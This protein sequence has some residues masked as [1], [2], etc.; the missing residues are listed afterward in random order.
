MA[1]GPSSTERVEQ[2]PGAPADRGFRGARVSR[3]AL[4]SFLTQMTTSALAGAL[5][6]FLSRALGSSGYGAFAFAIGVMSILL[7]FGDFGISPST[8]RF[9]AEHR[10]SIRDVRAIFALALRLKFAFAAVV[11][12][13]MFALAGPIS[14][15]FGHAA[16]PWTLRAAAIALFGQSVLQ[17]PLGSFEAL[18]RISVSWRIATTESVIEVAATVALVLGSA[19]ATSAMFGRAIG[20]TAGTALALVFV[21]RALGGLRVPAGAISPV[22]RRR[23]LG[24]AVPLLL[25]D[26]LFRLF[27]SIDVLLIAAI[28]GGGTNVAIYA[29]PMRL[30]WFLHYPVGSVASAVVPRLARGPDGER[31]VES[32]AVTLRYVVVLQMALVPPILVWAGPIIT[33]VSGPHYAAAIPVLRALA[34]FVFLSGL[35]MLLSLAVNY[36]GEARRRVP[37][38]AAALALNTVIDVLLLR[39]IG[40]IAGAYG[41]TAAYVVWTLAHLRILRRA[42]ALPLGPLLR[43][44]GRS[45][46]AAAAMSGVLLAFGTEHLSA[47]DW[48]AGSIAGAAVYGAVLVATR[49]LHRGDLAVARRILRRQPVSA[50]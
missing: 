44:F 21:A 47:F 6:V 18:R 23:L 30:A 19:T 7:L 25:V 50:A 1:R 46:L 41:S 45:L 49:E 3:N 31:D 8:N 16:S 40:P 5:T 43:S 42:L 11:S 24:Y 35:A 26:G 10:G 17:L 15:A 12:V 36:L 28:L 20:F 14:S 39:S 4:W 38:A 32:F 34:P 9:L 29:L 2:P 27:D 48:I 37:I 22:P 13:G 33:L